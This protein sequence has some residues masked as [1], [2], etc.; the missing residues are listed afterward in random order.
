MYILIIVLASVVTGQA[1]TAAAGLLTVMEFSHPPNYSLCKD[2]NDSRQLTDGEL[3]T[4]PI[5]M[6][7][8]TVG[9]AAFTPVAIQLRVAGGSSVQSPQAGK[10]RLHS[11]KGLSA[12]VDVP[13]QIN[14]YT[15]DYTDQLRIVGS[16]TPDSS[17]LKDK[18]AHWIQIDVSAATDVLIVVL[19]ASGEFLFLDE[20]EW[21]PSGGGQ[22]PA[23]SP[24]MTSV[25]AALDDSKR[26]T[27]ETLINAAEVEVEKGA[28]RLEG[29]TLHA[30]IQDPWGVIDPGRAHEQRA[31]GAPKVEIR[32]YAGERESV[33]IGVAAG[34]LAVTGGLRVKVTGLPP[35]A[36]KIFEVRPVL[37]ANGRRIYDP[38]VPLNDDM[39][40]SMRAGVPSYIWL[41]VNLRMLGPGSHRL[42]INLEGN[43]QMIA[44]PG[45]ATVTAYDGRGSKSLHAVNWAYLSDMPIFRD[46][47]NAIQD[48][49]AHGIN[50]FVTHPMEIPG[51]ALDGSWDISKAVR[52]AR[53][54]D[55][56]KQH[57][58][59]LLYLGWNASKNPLGFSSNERSIDPRARER[60]LTWVGNVSTYLASQGLPPERWA[61]Y[62]VD[63]PDRA[64]LQLIK[65]VAETVKQRNPFVRVYANPSVYANPPI[66]MDHLRE[67]QPWVDLWQPNLLAVRGQL[68]EFFK[69]LQAEW[70]IYGNP[71]SP[72]KGSSPLHNYRLLAWW[73]W[74]Y[75]ATGIGFWSY[76]DTNGSSAWDDLDGS[77]SDW[78]VVYESERGV[79]SSRRWE[80]F[81]EGLEDHALL[82]GFS[83]VDVKRLLQIANEPNFDQW[84]GANL[85]AVR[86]VLLDGSLKPLSHSVDGQ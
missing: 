38:L 2:E 63:E 58:T 18:N 64:G 22:I 68:G 41:D 69:N 17:V 10:L 39:Q 33:C 36:V 14:V 35:A 79:V 48:L 72:A 71:K 19:H 5:W 60:L 37:V 66:T 76:S 28:L 15:R 11:A 26:R 65:A 44:I 1:G 20:V 9:W 31:L 47:D 55:L 23:K 73:A 78:A 80:A 27:R 16:L 40:L 49:V 75:G 24:A 21:H 42:E 70:W 25:R 56:A 82:A 50:M 29:K 53:T 3:A 8:E 59:L 7:K 46:R 57:G 34:E 86:R 52:F 77:R 62:P 54:V 4:F 85:E 13:Q 83:K 51:L 32:G 74:H 12:G 67:I 30:W 45:M 61:L 84:E 6:K 81:R 43:G